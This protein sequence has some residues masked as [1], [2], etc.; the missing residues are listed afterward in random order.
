M[1]SRPNAAQGGVTSQPTA[2]WGAPGSSRGQQPLGQNHAAELSTSID[3]LRAAA[4]P[5]SGGG[6]RHRPGLPVTRPQ[7]RGHRGP[8][9]PCTVASSL[10]Q[11]GAGGTADAYALSATSQ[12]DQRENR[13]ETS[14][15][16]HS[17]ERGFA[18]AVGQS[19]YENGRL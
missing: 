5:G 9:R 8:C 13:T 4:E 1:Q 11:C 14:V 17:K 15:T 10:S 7:R 3:L 6:G 16:T 12:A 19:L 18:E 2:E